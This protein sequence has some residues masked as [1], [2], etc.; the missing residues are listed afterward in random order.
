MKEYFQKLYAYNAWADNRVLNCL[1]RQQVTDEKTLRVFGHE[2][3]AQLI[4]YA[5]IR[6]L[7]KSQL[8]LWADYSVHA[9][10]PLVE[11]ASRL[12][13]HYVN[14]EESFDQLLKYTNFTGAYYETVIRDL[15]CHIVNHS[16]YHRGQV[17]VLLR[18]KRYEPVNTDFITYDRILSGQLKENL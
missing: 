2:V 14:T 12:W 10:K 13:L 16:T 4:W 11:E 6:S 8:Q 3:S 15:M 5:R 1:E 18:E 7:P 17:A 9:L